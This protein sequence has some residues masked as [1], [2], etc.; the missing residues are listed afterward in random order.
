MRVFSG[1]NVTHNK[2][3]GDIEGQ[4]FLVTN[5]SAK[6]N[7]AL[8]EQLD[9]RLERMMKD[10]PLWQ[11]ILLW[12]SGLLTVMTNYLIVAEISGESPTPVGM[13]WA[14][15]PGLFVVAAIA[16][17]TFLVLMVVRV[18]WYRELFSDESE[19]RSNAKIKHIYQEI[20]AELGVPADAVT[21]D[22]LQFSYTRH[23]KEICMVA[24]EE[25]GVMTTNCEYKLFFD[26]TTVYLVDR[27]GKYA[28]S[29]AALCRIRTVDQWVS[30]LGWNKEKSHKS[31]PWSAYN[32]RE[33]D[34]AAIHVSP[35]YILELTKEGKTWGIWFPA[36]ELSAFETATGLTP[37]Q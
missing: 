30:M 20:Y 22:V 33:D 35:Y 19:R 34:N 37:E 28:F 18:R 24:D 6:W 15:A 3:N 21:V 17:V 27:D 25:F 10:P 14:R 9:V 7:D 23:G 29:R 1:V 4:E 16:G 2:A 13:L 11:T 8:D 32:L 26:D 36:Y 31:A 12:L 5:P